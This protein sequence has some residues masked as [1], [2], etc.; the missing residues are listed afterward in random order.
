MTAILN[1]KTRS[2]SSDIEE[3]YGGSYI[4]DEGELVIRSTDLTLSSKLYIP[5]TVYEKCEYTVFELEKIRQKLRDLFEAGDSFVSEHIILFGIDPVSNVFEVG[6]DEV[7]D[8]NKRYFVDNISSCPAVSFINCSRPVFTSSSNNLQCAER[9]INLTTQDGF[10]HFGASI[11]YRARKKESGEC[12]IVTAGHTFSKEQIVGI[13]TNNSKVAIGKCVD[14]RSYDGLLDAAF[15]VITNADYVP[16]NKIAFM[17]N[18]DIDTLSVEIATP[19]VN[20]GINFVGSASKR[21]YGRVYKD[22]YDLIDDGKRLLTD[23]L[24]MT[25]I[26]EYGDSGG[27]VYA[28][29]KKDNIRYT[30]GIVSGY[31]DLKKPLEAITT[32]Y[33]ICCKAN[34]INRN[35]GLERY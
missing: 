12:G 17:E 3:W 15:C 29:N 31:C 14:S 16:T 9:I 13:F 2:G 11:G 34:V 35:F 27:I 18:P 28:L 10:K 4:N 20:R 33:G 6:M 26:P 21:K 32:R 30:V 7:T 19:G 23:V 5:N 1:D 25:C 22:T 8:E 24:L